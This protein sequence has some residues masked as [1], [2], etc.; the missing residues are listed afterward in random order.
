M[1]LRLTRS[2]T[3]NPICRPA[4]N[5]TGA[6]TRGDLFLADKMTVHDA[7][8]RAV[9]IF[10]G[11][12]RYPPKL[13]RGER[14]LMWQ[15]YLPIGCNSAELNRPVD[16]SS[17]AL[18]QDRRIQN[19]GHAEKGVFLDEDKREAIGL[20]QFKYFPLRNYV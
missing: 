9:I 2:G 1:A 5:L 18:R 13:H 20:E 6:E 3:S 7:G 15:R 8:H 16:A 14:N 17:A 12:A 10:E 4:E 19:V 11:D